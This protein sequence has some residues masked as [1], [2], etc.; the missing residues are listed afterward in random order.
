MR[1]QVPPRALVF[2]RFLRQVLVSCVISVN[3]DSQQGLA[4][5]VELGSRGLANLLAQQVAQFVDGFGFC[6]WE[7]VAVGVDCQGNGLVSHD[8]QDSFRVDALS[9]QPIATVVTQG[10]EVKRFVGVVGDC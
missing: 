6:V 10:V 3:S 9:R 7:Q 8:R 2:R 5:S 4:G 1:V